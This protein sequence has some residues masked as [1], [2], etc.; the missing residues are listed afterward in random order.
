MIRLFFFLCLTVL[1]SSCSHSFNREW[2]S[3]LKAGPKTGVEG[4]WEGTWKSDVNG[5]NGRLR[6]VVGPVKNAEG[7]HSFH[8]HAT[9]AKILSGAYRV[10]HR[11]QTAKD[12]AIFKGQH[13]LPGWAGGLYTYDGTVKGDDFEARYEC[14]LDKGTFRMKRVK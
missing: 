4:A 2:K 13:K 12:G 5:H 11:V 10:D 7:D 9:W 6:S 3:A 14:D 8:Y 1:L